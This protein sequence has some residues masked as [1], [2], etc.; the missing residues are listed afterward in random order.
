MLSNSRRANGVAAL[1]RRRWRSLGAADFRLRP[2][3]RPQRSQLAA[4]SGRARRLSGHRLGSDAERGWIPPG[5]RS[6]VSTATLRR[7][8][9]RGGAPIPQA[10]HACTLGPRRQRGPT[11]Y[12]MLLVCSTRVKSSCRNSQRDRQRLPARQT[13][14]S[15][16]TRRYRYASVTYRLDANQPRRK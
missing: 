14:L 3:I 6:A 1:M 9:I 5:R 7:M 4:T 12:W 2:P 15:K 16:A 11:T 10:Q 13:R 8:T